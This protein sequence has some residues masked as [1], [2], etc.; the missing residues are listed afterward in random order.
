MLEDGPPQ[1][2]GMGS[3]QDDDDELMLSKQIEE[4]IENR[5]KELRN[6]RLFSA[7]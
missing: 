7:E 1:F 2:P 6:T 4:Q 3:E 5:I